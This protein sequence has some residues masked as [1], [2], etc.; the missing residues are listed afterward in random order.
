MYVR[1]KRFIAKTTR[2]N[3]L[4]PPRVLYHRASACLRPGTN[5]IFIYYL[6]L[7][8]ATL[9]IITVKII[10]HMQKFIIIEKFNYLVYCYQDPYIYLN[11]TGIKS[12]CVLYA[13]YLAFERLTPSPIKA[14]EALPVISRGVQQSTHSSD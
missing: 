10:C 12:R 1:V 4:I 14:I 7:L 8:L 5:R 3:D 13:F 11:L 6:Q 2:V 9:I